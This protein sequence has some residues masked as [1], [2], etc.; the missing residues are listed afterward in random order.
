MKPL[1]AGVNA[2]LG[3]TGA[4][5]RVIDVVSDWVPLD[6]LKAALKST[7]HPQYQRACVAAAPQIETFGGVAGGHVIEFM[8]VRPPPAAL[9][10]P[11]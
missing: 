2:V 3:D 6:K 4:V 1:A 9:Y 11:Q 5:D 8:N 7:L 10:H